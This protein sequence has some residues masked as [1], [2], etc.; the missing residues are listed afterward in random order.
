[1]FKAWL[2]VP[3]VAFVAL[4]FHHGDD[5]QSWNKP[6]HPLGISRVLLG[7]VRRQGLCVDPGYL[8]CEGSN[9]C[10]PAGDLCC[11]VGTSENVIGNPFRTLPLS[12]L[13]T[14]RLYTGCCP[15]GRVL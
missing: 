15:P 14:R 6:G 13:L 8:P 5:F 3:L 2:F 11:S 12:L 4:A 7:L 9:D 1:M 10:C